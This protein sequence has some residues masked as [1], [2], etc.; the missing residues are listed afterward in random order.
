MLRC[1][2]KPVLI[3]HCWAYLLADVCVRG[4]D[5]FPTLTQPVS[6]LASPLHA[7]VAAAQNCWTHAS[8]H[9]R[10]VWRQIV[11]VEEAAEVLEA[12]ILAGLVPQTEQ[13]ILIGDHKQLRPKIQVSMSQRAACSIIL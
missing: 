8:F 12:H 2:S 7:F 6:H 11:V 1:R 13:L 4:P 10:N 5:G 3:L 9:L